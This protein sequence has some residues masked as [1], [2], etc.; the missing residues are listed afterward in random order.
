LDAWNFNENIKFEA[1]KPMTLKV[2]DSQIKKRRPNCTSTK[3]Y[4]VIAKE[5]G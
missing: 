5:A 4:S 1:T 2:I 3:N